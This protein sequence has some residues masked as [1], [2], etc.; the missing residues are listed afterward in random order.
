MILFASDV[1]RMPAVFDS[2]GS[3]APA[4][5]TVTS[6][7]QIPQY[8][9]DFSQ[10][11]LAL[12]QSLASNPYPQYQGQLVAPLNDLQ[13]QGIQQ[14][15]AASTAYQPD[16]TAA[17]TVAQ[18]ALSL[19]PSNP[20]QVSQFMSPYVQASLQPQLLAAQTQLGQEQNQIGAQATGDNAFGDARQGVQSSLANFYG[21]QNMAGIEATGYNTAF[22]NAQ[23]ALLG[24]QQAGLQGA[25]TLGNLGNEA[26]SAGITGANATYNAGTQQQTQ[27]QT[28]LNTAYQNFL[29]QTQWPQQQLNMMEGALANNPYSTVNNITVPQAN[30]TS[31]GIGS[32]A[33]LAG[34]LGSLLSGSGSKAPFGGAALT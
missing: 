16:L 33:S 22:N 7:Q 32:F 17:N 26:Q 11:N 12:A 21:N 9:Q 2:G 10:G 27:Q 29:N 18:N 30:G 15:T 23:T 24:Q 19:D 14:A 20:G 4:S 3:S 25:S 6:S 8:E 13:N 5:N 1:L 31:T 28:E 34:G